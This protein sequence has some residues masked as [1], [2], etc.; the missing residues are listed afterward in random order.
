MEANYADLIGVHII[1]HL[2]G[3]FVECDGKQAQLHGYSKHTQRDF[4]PMK[5]GF[6]VTLSKDFC[7]YLVTSPAVKKLYH[8]LKFTTMPDEKFI[9]TALINSPF[10]DTWLNLKTM[11]VEWKANAH[12]PSIL[13]MEHFYTLTTTPELFARKFNT[14]T[15]DKELLDKLS[16]HLLTKERETPLQPCHSQLFKDF[17]TFD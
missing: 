10:K 2:E 1:S 11:F 8:F 4:L 14:E 15:P 12:H 17:N 6:W 16:E 7:S 9:G 5:G 13:T 3:T